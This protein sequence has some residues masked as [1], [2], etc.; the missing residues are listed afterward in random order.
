MSWVMRNPLTVIY[1]D[2]C[3]ICSREVNAYR[4]RTDDL[5]VQYHGLS[6]GD[7]ERFGL[8]ED[9]AARQFHV[10]RGDER[11]EGLEAFA[12]LWARMPGLRWLAWLVTRPGIRGLAGLVYDRALAPLL[13]RMHRRRVLRLQKARGKLG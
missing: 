7:L 10:M 11:L 13:Y 1:N 3:P 5:E 4:R 8:T 12:A 2:T 6:R 9:R